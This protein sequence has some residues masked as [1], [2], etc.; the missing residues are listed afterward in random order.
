MKNS[1]ALL[2]FVRNSPVTGEFPSQRGVTRSFDV[3]FDWSEVWLA[4]TTL[5]LLCSVIWAWTHGWV[6]NETPVIW[7]KIAPIMTYIG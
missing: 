3:F 4:I 2:P 7:D 6:D 5:M 1:S